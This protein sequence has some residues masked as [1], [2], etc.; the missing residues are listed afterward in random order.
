MKTCQIAHLTH[1]DW[2]LPILIFTNAKYYKSKK[3]I[4]TMVVRDKDDIISSA[5]ELDY[6]M[7]THTTIHVHEK[8]NAVFFLSV[9]FDFLIVNSV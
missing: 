1:S 5:I 6:Q 3:A 4:G 7:T 9:S 2:Y 8:R